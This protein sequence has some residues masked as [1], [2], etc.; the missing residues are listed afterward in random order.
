MAFNTYNLD[1]IQHNC[2]SSNLKLKT[3]CSLKT[4]S[5][6]GHLFPFSLMFQ[7]LESI[8]S[9]GVWVAGGS[10]LQLSIQVSGTKLCFLRFDRSAFADSLRDIICE[11]EVVFRPK[12]LAKMTDRFDSRFGPSWVSRL[13]VRAFAYTQT[14]VTCR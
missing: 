9:S 13:P 7:R 2:Y 11:A 6:H 8:I 14:P 5:P 3:K 12:F 4:F 1:E 10:K